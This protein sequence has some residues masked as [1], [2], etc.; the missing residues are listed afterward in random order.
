MKTIYS[1]TPTCS[2]FDYNNNTYKLFK[3][4]FSD[5][6][7]DKNTIAQTLAVTGNN[8]DNSL[9]ATGKIQFDTPQMCNPEHTNEIPFAQK[10]LRAIREILIFKTNFQNP[11]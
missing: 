3:S 2:Y 1:Q 7:I 10:M 6:I 4:Q 8:R 9:I 11:R 5:I